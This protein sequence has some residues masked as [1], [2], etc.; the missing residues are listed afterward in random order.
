MAEP[1]GLPVAMVTFRD[2]SCVRAYRGRGAVL[3]WGVGPL[4]C[5][6]WE[7]VF[8]SCEDA[9]KFVRSRGYGP[10]AVEPGQKGQGQ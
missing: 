7:Q 10:A 4:R 9:V 6:R 3:W 5:G 1:C 8:S 2:G